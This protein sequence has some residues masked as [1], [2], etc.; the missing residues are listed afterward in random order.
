MIN[1]LPDSQKV[2]IRKEYRLRVL[3]V[4]LL[5]MLSTIVLTG[6]LLLPSY[7]LVFYKTKTAE[8]S[9]ASVQA[10][11]DAKEYS[12]RLQA[13]KQ[14][15]AMIKPEN[16]VIAPTDIIALVI[17]HKSKPISI[18]SITYQRKE[19]N[20]LVVRVEGKAGTRQ[21]LVKFKD[22]IE[23]DPFVQMVDLPVS[24][25]AQNTNI[26]FSLHISLK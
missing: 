3:V 15:A 4:T 16:K 18:T 9:V 14:A 12:E 19:E 20:K 5:F 2:L 26:E 6:L 11:E 25:F 23:S 24:S 8:K 7:L 13:A 22:G 10:A 17:K 21:D 1:L